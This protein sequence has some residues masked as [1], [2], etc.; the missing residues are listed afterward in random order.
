MLVSDKDGYEIINLYKANGAHPTIPDNDLMMLTEK[1]E[2][3]VNIY[4]LNTCYPSKEEA[5]ANID[6]DYEHEYVRTVKI[7]WEE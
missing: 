7:E 4:V 6:R 3:W 2:G 1:K 5:E